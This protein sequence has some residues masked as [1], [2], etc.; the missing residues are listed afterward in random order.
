MIKEHALLIPQALTPAAEVLVAGAGE[1]PLSDIFPLQTM[2]VAG[3]DNPLGNYSGGYVSEDSPLHRVHES[4]MAYRAGIY[5]QEQEQGGRSEAT[6]Q[7]LAVTLLQSHLAQCVDRGY[8][9]L[10]ESGLE[11]G[12]AIAKVGAYIIEKEGTVASLRNQQIAG[13]TVRLAALD[14][15][16]E[17][18]KPETIDGIPVINLRDLL[19]AIGEVPPSEEVERE[20]TR[21]F[22]REQLSVMR[23]RAERLKFERLSAT[24]ILRLLKPDVEA[25]A[26]LN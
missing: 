18:S 5:E 8:H 24:A 3:A 16:E 10:L 9:N 14:R 25:M 13:L 23:F 11:P 12:P 22:V 20:N 17:E 15:Q 4:I 2:F 26:R 1:E 7:G 19:E 6:R 21:D